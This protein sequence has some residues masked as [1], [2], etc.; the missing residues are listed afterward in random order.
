M[1]GEPG[2]D[3][4]AACAPVGEQALLPHGR[5]DADEGRAV[6]A[7]EHRPGA[8]AVFEDQDAGPW[9]CRKKRSSGPHPG[10]GVV[11][12]VCFDHGAIA[13]LTGRGVARKAGRAG[14]NRLGEHR[15]RRAPAE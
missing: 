1:I 9:I 13:D 8:M 3:V 4:A 12:G 5:G 10:D 11:G 7:V 6:G 15:I 14:A 2:V